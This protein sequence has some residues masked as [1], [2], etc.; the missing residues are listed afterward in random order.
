VVW[1]FESGCGHIGNAKTIRFDQDQEF[2]GRDLELLV[3]SIAS[4][5]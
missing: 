2:I 5:D 1:T 4:T 3:R